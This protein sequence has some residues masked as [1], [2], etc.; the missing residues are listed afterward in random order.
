MEADKKLTDVIAEEMGRKKSTADIVIARDL[1]A[2]KSFGGKDVKQLL[3]HPF[4]VFHNVIGAEAVKELH[5]VFNKP[6]PLPQAKP[7]S[8]ADVLMQ[9]AKPTKTAFESK[10]DVEDVEEFISGYTAASN[11]EKYLLNYPG[12]KPSITEQHEAYAVSFLNKHNLTY[13]PGVGGEEVR[14]KSALSKLIRTVQF[15]TDHRDVMSYNQMTAYDSCDLLEMSKDTV[16]CAICYVTD[17]ILSKDEIRQGRDLGGKTPLPMC[18]G[19]FDSGVKAPCS[20]GRANV[21]HATT[22]KRRKKRRQMN[23]SGRAGRRN[24]SRR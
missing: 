5:V 18:R 1:K 14:A 16:M 15:L 2:V 12:E 11:K 7:P 10:F 20:G 8:F 21:M 3:D 17:D 19:C 22:Q 4:S 23:Q 6:I 24:A 13:S 9:R